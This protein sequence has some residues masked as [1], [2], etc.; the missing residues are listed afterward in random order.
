MGFFDKL[1]GAKKSK[2][3]H[4]PS[5]AG[6]LYLHTDKG[7]YMAGETIYGTCYIWA[8]D[9][10][11]ANYLEVKIGGSEKVEYAW[12]YSTG[13]GE[14][15]EVHT[16][17][18]EDK[19][20]V[21]KKQ[22]KLLGS[23]QFPQGYWAY[24]WKFKLPDNLPG[25][26]HWDEKSPIDHKEDEAKIKYTV[27]AKLDVP[28]KD[29]VCKQPLMIYSRPLREAHAP[30]YK[31]NHTVRTCGCVPR[32]DISAEFELDRSLY[33]NGDV[34]HGVMTVENGSSVEVDRLEVK[35][36]R[37]IELRSKKAEHHNDRLTDSDTIA[38]KHVDGVPAGETKKQEITMPLTFK[39]YDVTPSARSKLIKCKYEFEGT[40][41]VP[42][43]PD[44]EF[45]DNTEIVVAENPYWKAF[46]VPE[47]AANAQV[48]QPSGDAG[49]SQEEAQR[50]FGPRGMAVG[51]AP[52]AASAPLGV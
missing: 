17:R 49:M 1:F 18:T 45:E 36:K 15:R 30:K 31:K 41:S 28:G 16:E 10:L 3:E 5:A 38:K 42:W 13:V 7:V 40:V 50:A 32:G 4:K 39:G 8:K 9:N 29:L 12:Q 47:W 33:R 19:E 35:L 44:M 2:F 26:F 21:I 46:K 27:T 25:T 23:G 6:E 52:A 11:P 48:M 22:L 43:A 14:E 34:V 24:N 51:A 37:K 20:K